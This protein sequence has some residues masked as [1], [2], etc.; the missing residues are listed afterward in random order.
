MTTFSES[1]A[2]TATIT[3]TFASLA[4]D[5]NLL[6]GR[7][8]TVVDNSSNLYM[9]ALLSGFI[10]TGTSPT[11]ST[12][13]YVYLYGV[14]DQTPT[15]PD[16]ITGSDANCSLTSANVRNSFTRLVAAITVDST[17]NRKYPFGP[18]SVAQ[19]F[20]GIMPYKWGVWVVQNTGAALNATGGN[21]QIKYDGIK[22][23]SA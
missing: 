22:M 20:G 23:T 5:T 1:I 11:V 13:I 15:Y 10:S 6:A 14:L 4:S 9:D 18:I 8:C 12:N 17:S 21:H 2:G 16:T 7:E 19:A 3:L